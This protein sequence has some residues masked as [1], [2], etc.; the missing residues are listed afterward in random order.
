[1]NLEGVSEPA[2]C[3]LIAP[4]RHHDN[5]G[6]EDLTIAGMATCGKFTNGLLTTGGYASAAIQPSSR[7]RTWYDRTASSMPLHLV[8]DSIR[9]GEFIVTLGHHGEQ[10]AKEQ[11]GSTSDGNSATFRLRL[12]RVQRH[13]TG[14]Q[15]I[16]RAGQSR[17]A[18]R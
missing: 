3:H 13:R 16:A 10:Y 11:P 4:F 7:R 15:A 1:M 9:E 18:R 2:S 8:F 6:G 17:I 5:S 14:V 12:T